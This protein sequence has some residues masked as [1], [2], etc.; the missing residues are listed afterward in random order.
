MRALEVPEEADA[1]TPEDARPAEEPKDAR[2]V[3]VVAD[4]EFAVNNCRA[5]AMSSSRTI[6]MMT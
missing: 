6:A 4:E 2:P 5:R 1:A 3:D